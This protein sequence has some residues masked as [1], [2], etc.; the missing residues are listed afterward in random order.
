MSIQR[1]LIW[2]SVLTLPVAI[3]M[4]LMLTTNEMNP[5]WDWLA[6]ACATLVI[7]VGAG[8]MYKSAWY[9]F[10][11]HH[12]NMDTLVALGT[13]TAYLASIWGMVTHRAVFF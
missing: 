8:E 6:L 5:L 4:F 12:A 7:V 9:A 3:Q 1:R 2:S 13:L 10:L 11:N